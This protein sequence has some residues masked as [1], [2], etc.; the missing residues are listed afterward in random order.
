MIFSEQIELASDGHFN[1]INITQKV[2]EILLKS[3]IVHGQALVFFQ[4]TTGSVLIGEFEV[5]IVADWIDMFE[6]IAPGSLAY[7]HHTRAVDYNGHA[8][9]RASIMPTQVTIPVL[10]GK[11]ALGTYQEILVIDDQVDKEPRYLIVQI[12]GDKQ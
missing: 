12:T 4:H 6:R 2:K 9:C 3:G 5:G 8:H 10:N 7:K 1:V 11:L